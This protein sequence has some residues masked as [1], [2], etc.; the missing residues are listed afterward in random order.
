MVCNS[1][2]LGQFYMFFNAA[3]RL[4][5]SGIKNKEMNF[6]CKLFQNLISLILFFSSF[7][8]IVGNFYEQVWN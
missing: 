4:V 7:W 8:K 5:P 2:L 6:V 1:A 3:S